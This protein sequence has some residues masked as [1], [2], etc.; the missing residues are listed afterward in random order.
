M[1]I[2]VHDQNNA[3]YNGVNK[4][5]ALGWTCQS[6]VTAAI[7]TTTGGTYAEKAPEVSPKK[8]VKTNK[9]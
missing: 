1:N 4:A 6:N 8:T 9:K 7:V 3:Y 2:S 5:W